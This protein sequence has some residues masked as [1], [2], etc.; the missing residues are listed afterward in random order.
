MKEDVIPRLLQCCKED[1][2][3]SQHNS[4]E[5]S[6]K[7]NI[8]VIK[9]LTDSTLKQQLLQESQPKI[10]ISMLTN[11][12]QDKQQVIQLPEAKI[13]GTC[14]YIYHDSSTG[15]LTFSQL[16]PKAA[17][18]V[19]RLPTA[20]ELNHSHN[21][22]TFHSLSKYKRSL[23]QLYSSQSQIHYSSKVIQEI[24]ILKPDAKSINFYRH[25]EEVA[26][27]FE[28]TNLW[29]CSHIKITKKGRSRLINALESPPTCHSIHFNY[30]PKNE[31]DL[32]INKKEDVIDVLFYS[33]F[34]KSIR[35]KLP[36]YQIGEYHISH[37]QRQLAKCT[38]VEIIELSFL[39][40]LLEKTSEDDFPSH[41]FKTICQ[42]LEN[43]VKI[44]PIESICS[45]IGAGS[46]ENS[47]KCAKAMLSNKMIN[48]LSA[49]SLFCLSAALTELLQIEP[50]LLPSLIPYLILDVPLDQ[51]EQNNLLHFF[52][53]D[54]VMSPL[55]FGSRT[56][57]DVTKGKMPSTQ[58]DNNIDH[59]FV[60]TQIAKMRIQ[61]YKQYVDQKNY[62]KIISNRN[63]QDLYPANDE[64]SSSPCNLSSPIS[65]LKVGRKALSDLR[66]N[67]QEGIFQLHTEGEESKTLHNEEMISTIDD[68]LNND[69]AICVSVL[70]GFMEQQITIPLVDSPK[71]TAHILQTSKP[72]PAVGVW[73]LFSLHMIDFENMLR[74]KKGKALYVK[75]DKYIRNFFS[76]GTSS[77]PDEMYTGKLQFLMHCFNN[78]VSSSQE[79]I[80]YSLEMQLAEL[81]K[82]QNIQSATTVSDLISKWNMIFKETLMFHV[83]EHFRPLVAR[84]ILWCLNIHNLREELAS[85]T[86]VAIAGL[87]NSGKS[88]L[89][90][91]LFKQEIVSGTMN[92]H[93]T[94]V[95]F[96]YNLDGSV[97][98]LSVIDFPGADD[99]D[100][101]VVELSEILLKLSQL[102]VLVIDYK[103]R[104][105]DSAKTWI[106]I[107]R[108]ADVPVLVCLTY[109]DKLYANTFMDVSSDQAKR[110]LHQEL[111]EIC[112]K[113]N[114]S[115]SWKVDLFS[116]CQDT[117]SILNNVKGRQKLKDVG[118]LSCD[119][120]GE[121]IEN[122]LRTYMKEEELAER[123]KSFR[124]SGASKGRKF[125]GVS[126]VKEVPPIRSLTCYGETQFLI[127]SKGIDF[128]WDGF[129]LK[130]K[131]PPNAISDSLTEIHVKVISSGHY[132]LPDN[133]V[134]VSPLFWLYSPKKFLKYI[135]L[136]IEHCANSA[137]LKDN[138]LSFIHGRC[139]Q[140]NL[141]YSFKIRKEGNFSSNSRE[142]VI[143]LK[144]FCLVGIISQ[145]SAFYPALPSAPNN[146][147]KSFDPSI[148]VVKVFAK[149]IEPKICK[150]DFIF[151]KDLTSFHTRIS[152]E[153]KGWMHDVQEHFEMG[154][155]NSDVISLEIKASDFIGWKCI[156]KNSC[157]IARRMLE[158]CQPDNNLLKCC[159]E[160]RW[161]YPGDP[162]PVESCVEINGPSITPK[163]TLTL[164]IIS[165]K[166]TMIET[167]VEINPPE[168]PLTSSNA[169]KILRDSKFQFFTF[170]WNLATELDV[171]I[172]TK[173]RLH[174]TLK[175][176]GNEL[177]ATEVAVDFWIRNSDSANWDKFVE[178]IRK[179]DAKVADDVK[180]K[181]I[182]L[183]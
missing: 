128:A 96:L 108:N 172:D 133:T 6:D 120:V 59:E 168:Y 13:Y 1:K 64:K 83:H 101:T 113:L 158:K 171:E 165:G 112:T 135:D 32:L 88:C 38:P 137:A 104:Y 85:H 10:D 45:A 90:K 17:V 124:T 7:I 86:T 28:G 57:S 94:T 34:T 149:C 142:G 178:A 150:F 126:S 97:D 153:Y 152:E 129:G 122:E 145:L 56:F 132:S 106:E 140:K 48:P 55:I 33:H 144:S 93:R 136:Q 4:L 169:V 156:K 30:T 110:F 100:D 35:K 143:P 60:I 25:G 162:L 138:F 40:A 134:L 5:F 114:P 3:D 176:N 69:L 61:A 9:L 107:L 36:A 102:V 125:P 50:D 151:I 121:W 116:F 19:L 62:K 58:D 14:Q 2:K 79:Y 71:H 75:V 51:T 15:T 115:Q 131:V 91:T 167:T 139:D 182:H 173:N 29:F 11:L 147:P 84:W 180:A 65:V 70:G 141:P 22:I 157:E 76:K 109:G 80:S 146:K 181:L 27:V 78:S 81:C 47:W 24:P 99:M 18:E 82:R 42:F 148:Y 63:I 183:L 31:D 127:T 68:I 72:P 123:L 39:S 117:D 8:A 21:L 111:L 87:S 74:S 164:P 12:L 20:E 177:M 52:M 163:L 53:N 154:D 103:R 170:F 49:S 73:G 67:L 26:L 43:S 119:D 118:I 44:V 46:V 66:K 174:D 175:A 161:Q 16:A 89:V 160:V 159:L 92:L 179:C 95:P 77:L 41:R 37:R 98:G 54:M 105:T 130:I 23:N 166:A 155:S